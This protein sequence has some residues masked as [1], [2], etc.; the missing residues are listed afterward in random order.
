[1]AKQYRTALILATGCLAVGMLWF[2]QA[3]LAS[4]NQDEYGALIQEMKNAPRGPFSRIRWFC[5]DGAILPP[6]PAACAGHGGGRQHGQL[7]PETRTLRESGYQVGNVLAAI[8]IEQFFQAQDWR[9]V[10]AQILLERFLID[11]DDGWI[12]RGAR[13]YRGALQVEDEAEAALAMNRQ[14]SRFADRANQDFLLLRETY[15]LLPREVD[16]RSVNA[17]R[18]LAGAITESDPAFVPVRSKIHNQPDARDA[19]RVRQHAARIGLDAV[20]ADYEKLALMIE[21]FYSADNISQ[22]IRE[23]ANKLLEGEFRSTLLRAADKL[24]VNR[25]LSIRLQHTASLLSLL[26]NKYAAFRTDFTRLKTL[27]LSLRLEQEVFLIASQLTGQLTQPPRN[28]QL[29]QLGALI[30]ASYGCGLLSERQRFAMQQ[31]LV[32]LPDTQV[33]LTRY[34]DT[35]NY[36]NR[37]PGW[38]GSWLNFHF[39]E[40]QAKLSEIEPLVLHFVADRLRSSPLLAYSRILDGLLI[41][42]TAHTGITHQLFGQSV[43]AGLRVL[44]PGLARGRLQLPQN[45]Q[46]QPQSDSIVLLPE[47]TSELPPVAGILTLGEGNALSHV[48]LLAGNLGIPN[49]VISSTLAA[50]LDAYENQTVVMAVSPGGVVHLV[51]DNPAWHEYFARQV[52]P[53]AGLIHPD[54]EKLDL[55][56]NHLFSLGE[57]RSV[58]AGRI[59]GPKAANLGELKH[60]FPAAVASGLVIPF[61]VFREF[62]QQPYPGT[63]RSAFDWMTSEYQRIDQMLPT[64]RAAARTLFLGKL[65][66]WILTTDPGPFFRQRL[67]SRL[68]SVFGAVEQYSL[69]VRSDTNVEDL[70]GFTGAGLNLTVPNVTGFE[71][72]LTAIRQVWASPFS[73]RAFAWRQQ[74][75]SQPQHVYPSVLLMESVPVEKSGVMLTLDTQT[76]ERRLLTLATNHGIGGAVQGQSAEEL[77]FDPASGE[78]R[79][80]ADATAARQKVLSANGGLFKQQLPADGRVLTSSDIDQLISFAGE[81]SR[82]FPQLDDEGE[83]TAADV[84]FG[85]RDG[86]LVLFQVRPYLKNRHLRKHAYLNQLDRG[87]ERG[88]AMVVNLELP[89]GSR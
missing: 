36:L 29:Q 22:H 45:G 75:M 87:L 11:Y 63:E 31:A 61:A 85:F 13:S 64:Q 9:P 50:G 8:D 6:E 56:Q 4:T 86:Q 42:A 62:L 16:V 23:Y 25:D 14:L 34:R 46:L 49:V 65:R 82:K 41:D 2:S 20:Q 74:R 78:L 44:N 70:P 3:A 33:M 83:Q 27:A 10:L 84:E 60:H 67:R 48:Q 24:A 79:L 38:A 40:S 7:S 72:L 88:T 69:F 57:L 18:D 66:H 80:L 47:T 26:R 21:L 54:L 32:S 37:L 30:E 1:M 35:L 89:A 59:A 77:L 43:G 68:E 71:D 81:L 15:R 12:Y 52:I 55:T 28:R 51:A 17:I 39:A 76:G 73:D 58:H 53:E 19:L 5:E